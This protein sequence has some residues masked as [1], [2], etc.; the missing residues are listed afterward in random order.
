ML[1]NNLNILAKQQH[2]LLLLDIT[3]SRSYTTLSITAARHPSNL[4]QRE[5][6]REREM[7]LSARSREKARKRS[8]EQRLSDNL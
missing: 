8:E 5:G 6:K 1:S 4:F 3:S 2:L 7:L